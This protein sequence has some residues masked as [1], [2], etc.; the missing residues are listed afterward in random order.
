[1]GGTK[2]FNLK[3]EKIIKR[4]EELLHNMSLQEKIG[5]LVQYGRLNEAEREMIKEGEIGSFLNFSGADAVNEAQKT[6]L[7]SNNPIPLLIGD[8]VIHGYKTTFPIPLAESCSWDLELMEDTS[9]ISAKEASTEGV[10]FIFAPMVD[11]ARDPRWGRV[12]EGAGEDTY[13][14]SLI[15]R[16]RVR[17]IQRND[18]NDRPHITACPKHFLGYGAAVGG[19]DYNEVDLSE[20]AIR[21]T[22]LPPFTA[23]FQEGALTTMCAFHDLNGIPASGNKFLLDQLLRKEL[24]FE[25]LVISDWESV[26]ELIYHG[27]AEDK[28]EASIKGMEVGVDIDMHSGSYRENL[29]DL[30]KEGKVSEEL[31]DL[32]VG[33]IL[34]VKLALGLF[35]NPYTDSSLNS[36]IIRAQEHIDKA[37]EAAR[38]SIVL[39]KNANM[40]PLKKDYKSVSVI[41]PFAKEPWSHLGCWAGKCNPDKVV[42]VFEGIKNKLGAGVEVHYAQGSEIFKPIENGLE[43]ALKAAEK[44]EVVILTVGD[45][46]QSG[47]NRNRVNID[48][49][50]AQREFIEAIVKTGKP[51]VM[52]LM[53]GRPLALEWE[54]EHIPAILEVWNG[55]EQAGNAVAD[56]LFGDFNPSG[57]LTMTFPRN[58]GQ[59]PIYYNYKNTGRPNFK[60][61]LDSED[62]PLYPFGYGLS[63]TTYEY[64]NIKISSKQIK[65]H[66]TLKVSAEIKN[67]GSR[68]GEEIVQ[69]YIRD[70]TASVT[71]PVKELRG[72]KKIALE[73]G[74]SMVVEFE[75]T[76]EELG[77]L[78]E[79][80][81]FVVEPGK[82]KVWVAPNS[83]EGLE[84]SFEVIE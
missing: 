61:Y 46:D 27:L 63:Y 25:G 72:F 35:E 31:I 44:A 64:S 16:V 60:R 21:E 80:F 67:T 34:K 13:L 4:A 49:P 54:N 84:E 83:S 15:A 68:A 42:T 3:D 23:A 20:R 8:D 58:V 2:V 78:D 75:L 51:V 81:N 14:G 56:V 38:K 12:A 82:F 59:V 66:E 39:F 30:V 47:E 57:K 48:I 24:G 37:L 36:K 55:G 53:N 69:L 6:I 18:W 28:K 1:M 50:K 52:L 7:E 17:G 11:I 40:L 29:E 33:R 41:G 70:I 74:E 9:A 73:A 32:A 5:Q 10:N 19:R 65:A 62:T 26:E 71:R 77:F 22:Y 43:D 45:G 76:N 79:G